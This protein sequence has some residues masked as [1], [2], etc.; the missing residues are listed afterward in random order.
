MPVPD[1]SPIPCAGASA[2]LVVTL[3]PK[4]VTSAAGRRIEYQNILVNVGCAR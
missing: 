3:H 1:I 4:R 2:A